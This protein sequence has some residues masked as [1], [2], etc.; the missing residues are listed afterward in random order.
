MMTKKTALCLNCLLVLIIFLSPGV[1]ITHEWMAPKSAA[2]IKNP[3]VRNSD[4]VQRGKVIYQDNCASCHGD[5]IK[6]LSAQEAGLTVDTPNLKKR[7]LTHSDGDFFWK[8]QHGRE[9]MPSFS[10]SL[11]DKETWEVINYIRHEAEK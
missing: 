6:G 7:I 2:E 8:I 4:S 11:T 3:I 9:E 1:G 5:E 10:D